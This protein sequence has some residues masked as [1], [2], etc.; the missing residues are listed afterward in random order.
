MDKSGYHMAVG[1]GRKE[2]EVLVGSLAVGLGRPPL[3]I[4]ADTPAA[5]AVAADLQCEL[6]LGVVELSVGIYELHC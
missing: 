5:A 3:D 4:A 6:G 1:T 2:H